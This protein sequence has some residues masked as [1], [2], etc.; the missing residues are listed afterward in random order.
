MA[1][2]Y[3]KDSQ[4]VRL[5]SILLSGTSLLDVSGEL[6]DTLRELHLDQA[7]DLL[8][9]LL[10][11]GE[12]SPRA[13]ILASSFWGDVAVGL[14]RRLADLEFPP[15]TPHRVLVALLDALLVKAGIVGDEI[16]EL[17][18]YADLMQGYLYED[19]DERLKRL[20]TLREFHAWLLQAFKQVGELVPGRIQ[21]DN[22]RLINRFTFWQQQGYTADYLYLEGLSD[23]LMSSSFLHDVLHD[24]L[25]NLQAAPVEC[26]SL[27][28]RT[29]RLCNV[30]NQDGSPEKVEQLERI[31]SVILGCH[32]EIPLCEWEFCSLPDG[33]LS[34][35]MKLRAGQ[36]RL[37]EVNP[38]ILDERMC[39]CAVY[40]HPD[41]IAFVPSSFL[42]LDM[43]EYALSYGSPEN[44]RHIPHVLQ[45]GEMVALAVS[46]NPL[47]L[48]FAD[49]SLVTF[50]M[51]SSA[52]I[53]NGRALLCLDKEYFK[54][55]QQYTALVQLALIQYPDLIRYIP[56]AYLKPEVVAIAVRQDYKCLG[57]LPSFLRTADL[58]LRMLLL[59][60]R[61]GEFIPGN[62]LADPVFMHKAELIGTGW[63]RYV[64]D[65]LKTV[66]PSSCLP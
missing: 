7:A 49:P 66:E 9:Q 32:F 1:N 21:T 54:T 13:E 2:S 29:V 46:K 3:Y 44:L 31:N 6:C 39:R 5:G 34:S 51:A 65:S 62:L 26:R 45:T 15:D 37:Q 33:Y 38:S 23:D 41:D 8:L 10:D 25:S 50:E 47:A 20:A 58:M 22:R 30:I 55:G 14:V 43:V 57:K 64:P 42:S 53:R 59:D 48:R 16:D 18:T 56:M 11:D 40:V 61:L 60:P 27:V 4:A 19:R 63:E 12:E 28:A 36:V 24:D 35:Y 17:Q 52:V